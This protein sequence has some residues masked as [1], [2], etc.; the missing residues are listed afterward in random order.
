M[1]LEVTEASRNLTDQPT[2]IGP[3]GLGTKNH[4]AGEDQHQISSQSVSISE[5]LVIDSNSE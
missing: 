3:V 4:C 5:Q 2:V 1:D